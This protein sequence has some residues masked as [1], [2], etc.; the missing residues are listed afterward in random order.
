M[1]RPL[2]H[3]RKVPISL[4]KSKITHPKNLAKVDLWTSLLLRWLS[5]PIRS[6]V[7]DSGRNDVVPHVVTHKT[8]QR[9]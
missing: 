7:I 5:T 2:R 1:D 9:L 8:H 4:Q 3:V 6:S